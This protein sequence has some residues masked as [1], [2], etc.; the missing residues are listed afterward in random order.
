M[1]VSTYKLFRVYLERILV[2]G[3]IPAVVPLSSW[4]CVRL[5]GTSPT[6]RALSGSAAD[7]RVNPLLLPRTP[8]AD[9][10]IWKHRPLLIHERGGH[11]STADHR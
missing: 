7:G 9:P 10:C 11:C 4:Y 8:A 1:G 5:M 3:N 6:Q 2:S